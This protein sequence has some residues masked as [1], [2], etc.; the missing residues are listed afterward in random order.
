MT[1]I[2]IKK[3]ALAQMAVSRGEPAKN[4]EKAEAFIIEA[5]GAGADLL[6]FPEMMTTGFNWSFNRGYLNSAEK[7][8]DTLTSLARRYGIDVVGSILEKTVRNQSANTMYYIDSTGAVKLKYR[9]SHLFTLFGE[10]QHM[11]PGESLECAQTSIGY[12][13]PAICYDLRFPELF[14]YGVE[15]GAEAFILSAAFPH[16]R[17]D[18]W[19][20]L[21]Q[22]RAIENQ[23][24][25]IA[26][27]QC[28]VEL[29]DSDV[30]DIEYFGHSMIVDPWGTVL[31]E[32]NENE[33]VYFAEID[34]NDVGRVRGRLTALKDRRKDLF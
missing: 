21:I 22:A 18:H 32:A 11:E 27:N 33:G 20:V 15:R 12:V 34:L 26:V 30:G 6:V 16:P 29:H 19:K 24:F 2:R 17:M 5:S 13:C 14:R 9:K 8:L 10:E 28:G 23:A 25:V 7:D 3:I 1:A 31:V 4:L